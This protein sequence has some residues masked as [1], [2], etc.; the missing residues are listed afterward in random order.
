MISP[1]LGLLLTAALWLA[2][3]S[4]VRVSAIS[5]GCKE[6]DSYNGAW[7]KNGMT[8]E[9]C[10]TYNERKDGDDVFA[11]RGLVWWDVRA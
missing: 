7:R 11:E 10:K 2:F 4:A 6:R 5:G 1:R 9:Q 8:F 3:S